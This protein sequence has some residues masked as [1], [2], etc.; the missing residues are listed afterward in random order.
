M[1]PSNAPQAT[2][3]EIVPV[4]PT[5]AD[6]ATISHVSAQEKKSLAP[7][8]YLVKVLLEK[9]PPATATGWAL[10]V[11]DHRIPKYRDFR[12]G[13]FFKV[14][15]PQFFQDHQGQ[16][17]RFSANSR[18]FVDTGLKL[19]A[20]APAAPPPPPPCRGRKTCSNEPG[21]SRAVTRRG[22]SPAANGRTCRRRPC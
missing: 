10:Y 13:I 9:L 19:P 3:V 6:R 11:G 14:F 2:A 5:D 18:D 17:F 21:I 20:P 4:Q 16:P 12:G 22:A 8:T 1:P 7:V 15:D